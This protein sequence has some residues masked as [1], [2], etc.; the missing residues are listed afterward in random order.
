MS[1]A[2]GPPAQGGA[3]VGEDEGKFRGT[4]VSGVWA[5][6]CLPVTV[7]LFSGRRGLSQW[8]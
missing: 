7:C 2:S 6:L 4:V 3:V 1:A 8:E 5:E